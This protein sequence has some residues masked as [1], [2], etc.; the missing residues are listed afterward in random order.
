MT[1]L[2]ETREFLQKLADANGHLAYPEFA[3]PWSRDAIREAS[4]AG[5]VKNDGGAYNDAHEY[6]DLTAKGRAFAG[7]P[8]KPTLIGWIRNIL[9]S[10]SQSAT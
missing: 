2:Q 1:L 4:K 6:F 5:L 7:L 9:Q 3:V 8:K 10:S